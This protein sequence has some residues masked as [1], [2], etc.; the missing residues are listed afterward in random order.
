MPSA[1]PTDEFI[2]AAAKSLGITVDPGWM[3][4]V[5][6]NVEVMLMLARQLEEFPLPD[7]S[8]PAPVYKA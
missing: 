8:E 3:P 7:D 4:S 5:R 6:M 2:E 1:D